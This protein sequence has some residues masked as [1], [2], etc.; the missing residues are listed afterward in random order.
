MT[1]QS[2]QRLSFLVFSVVSTIMGSWV[3]L[4]ALQDNIVFYVTPFEM[5]NQ[6]IAEGQKIR[7][8]GFVKKNSV[9]YST[10]T[11]NKVIFVATDFKKEI[12]VEYQGSIPLLFREG[13]GVVAEGYLQDKGHF[14]AEQVFIKHDE[15]YRPPQGE[16]K[17]EQHG[18]TTL[19][20]LS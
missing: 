1:Y 7:L 11:H 15:N 3:I 6:K 20:A 9:I 17:T 13:Q 18:K 10:Q 5:S 19:K 14:K 2:K 16:E 12:A 8:G 4:K